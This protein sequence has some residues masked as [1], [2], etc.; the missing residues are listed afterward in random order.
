MLPLSLPSPAL[1]STHG[2]QM[3]RFMSFDACT[4]E[5]ALQD[6]ILCDIFQ[7]KLLPL[8]PLPTSVFFNKVSI[9]LGPGSGQGSAAADRKGLSILLQG[10]DLAKQKPQ[11]ALLQLLKRSTS[12][13][14]VSGEDQ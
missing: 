6:G 12:H 11:I 3:L 7:Q 10:P 14:K 1:S 5:E 2:T 13:A 8:R 4:R 9:P